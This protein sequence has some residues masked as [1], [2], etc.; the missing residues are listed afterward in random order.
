MAVSRMASD[1]ANPGGALSTYCAGIVLLTG[2]LY[3]A[4][5]FLPATTITSVGDGPD[6][7]LLHLLLGWASGLRGLPA[8]SANF[9]LWAA[10]AYL[11]AGRFRAAAVLGVA[12]A[13]L[14]LTTLTSFKADTKYAGYYVWQSSQIAFAI[15]AI[16]AACWFRRTRACAGCRQ[17]ESE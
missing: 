13:L 2:V 3:A 14:G 12:A 6:V 1:S 4:S 11:E 15:G 5:C 16:V 9:V 7:G 10:A 8:W 17:S